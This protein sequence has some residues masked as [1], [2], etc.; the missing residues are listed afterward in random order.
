MPLSWLAVLKMGPLVTRGVTRGGVIQ[1]SKAL[2]SFAGKK[3]MDLIP[4]DK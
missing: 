3:P 4:N 2:S 1:A